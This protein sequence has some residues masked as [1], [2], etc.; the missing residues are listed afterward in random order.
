MRDNTRTDTRILRTYELLTEA[1]LRLAETKSVDSIRISE[2]CDSAMVHRATFYNHFTDKE[3]FINFVIAASFKKIYNQS[4]KQAEE[5]SGK[6]FADVLML[7]LLTFAEQQ[8]RLILEITASDIGCLHD[9]IYDFYLEELGSMV[10][11]DINNVGNIEQFKSAFCHYIAGGSISLT[12]WWLSGGYEYTSKEQ[13]VERI[14]HVLR[15]LLA[16]D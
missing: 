9:R 13:L 5:D 4:L 1:F 15:T 2:I 16:G 3:D 12:R 8:R 10:I 14:K 6:S 7:N 11:P